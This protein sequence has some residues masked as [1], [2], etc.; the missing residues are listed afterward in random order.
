[1]SDVAAQ[2]EDRSAVERLR[3]VR[4]AW[5]GFAAFLLYLALSCLVWL[6]PIGGAI[7][8]RYVGDGWAD[9]RLYRWGL[10]WT[11][12]AILHG[13]SPLLAPNVFA[14]EGINLT[15]VTFV[16]SLGI[17]SYPLQR[18]LGSLITLN[19]LMLL[20]PALAAWATYLLC[21]R[22][23]RRYWP[24]VLG[25]LFLGSSSFIAG[26]MVDH[27]NLV[28]IFPVPL[29][30]YLVVR[31]LEGS[32][33]TIAFVGLFGLDALFLFG[34]STELFATATLFGAIAFVLAL[35]FAGR[36]AGRLVHAGLLIALSYVMVGV[37]LLPFVTDALRN[38][39]TEVLRPI[40]KTSIDVASWIVPREHQRIGGESFTDI[41]S[42][43]TANSQEDAGYVGVV[44]LVMLVGFL[45]TERKRRSTWALLAFLAIVAV[46]ASGPVL[47]IVGVAS[48]TMPGTLLTEVPLLQ[49]AT[50]QRFPVYAALA[51]GVVAA[52]W[53]ARVSGWSAWL[54]WG[55]AGVAAV[56][57]LPAPD[58]SLFHAEG[59]TPG[60]FT[61]GDVHDQ[62]RE[63]EIVFAITERPGT[64]L[65][66]MAS[67][68]FWYRIPEGYV[69]P[70]PAAY[71][72]QPLY[73]GLAVV[74]LNPYVPTPEDFATWLTDT[75]VGAVL[76]DDDAAWKFGYLL[77][78]VGLE[79]VH[80]GD[81]VSV[82]RPGA[83]GSIVNDPAGVVVGG[84]LDHVG[85]ELR[86]FS[87]PSLTGSDRVTG[88]DGRQTLFTFV[89]P[90]CSSCAEH[91]Q[92]LEDFATTHPDVRVIAVSSWDPEL[93][94][95]SMIRELALG[96]EVA[97][98]PLG[99][100]A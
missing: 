43:F 73:R 40:D 42:N 20:A 44:A 65:E 34:I 50:P 78:T 61:S 52:V 25:G 7:A 41:T 12:W 70:V 74:Q 62:I 98:D 23:T 96:Y 67:S 46:L 1:M 66:W 45:I 54:R 9:A 28:M 13:H 8:T 55:I 85:G 31:R 6:P 75:G 90:D 84:D 22:V 100:M 72:G 11:P 83:D 3:D 24:S 79:Q 82:W 80:Q 37:L 91:L 71:V 10:G 30:V 81:G 60:F 95:A 26:H 76:L 92:A 5:K 94:N 77:Q 16:P 39:P 68:D 21:H 48:I 29:A 99:R 86:A 97:Q 59:A 27:L 33:G 64:E 35:A 15:W 63:G 38:E 53:V 4:S 17:V 57:L 19:V 2:T 51:L 87:F 89:G 88:P 49:H 58:P 32:L 69:G 36:D 93:A 56:A 14:P 18:V 47:H